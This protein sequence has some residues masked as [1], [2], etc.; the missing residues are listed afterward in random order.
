MHASFQLPQPRGD[1]L[2]IQSTLQNFKKLYLIINAANITEKCIM[3][4]S[5]LKAVYFPKY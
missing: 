4:Q 2:H 1:A 5:H 3:L